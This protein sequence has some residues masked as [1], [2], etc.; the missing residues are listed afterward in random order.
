MGKWHLGSVEVFYGKIKNINFLYY[1]IFYN[2]YRTL[3]FDD[4]EI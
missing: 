3:D 4:S 1:L 2:K